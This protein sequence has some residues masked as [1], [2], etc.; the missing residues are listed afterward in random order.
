[1]AQSVACIRKLGGSHRRLLAPASVLRRELRMRPKGEP[2]IP[3]CVNRDAVP[4]TSRSAA[5]ARSP[6]HAHSSFGDRVVGGSIGRLAAGPAVSLTLQSV[7]KLRGKNHFRLWRPFLSLVKRFSF[8][9]LETM[10]SAS[11]PVPVKYTI[12]MIILTI[13]TTTIIIITIMIITQ[14]LVG[15]GKVN[16]NRKS[17]SQLI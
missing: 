4:W 10:I 15:A 16:E 1:M 5:V 7:G 8:F 3:L 6:A 11:T 2:G 12:I 17:W 9:L 13:T 14:V